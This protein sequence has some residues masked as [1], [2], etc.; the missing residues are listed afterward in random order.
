[1]I[2]LVPLS[3]IKK[4]SNHPLEPIH[5]P[6]MFWVSFLRTKLFRGGVCFDVEVPLEETL[7]PAEL[8]CV[9]NAEARLV[10]QVRLKYS[11]GFSRGESD[12]AFR[13]DSGWKSWPVWTRDDLP[14]RIAE[15]QSRYHPT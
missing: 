5:A 7:K 13:W 1:M 14:S 11:D 12:Y 10:I 2:L 15:E 9:S 3:T 8:M 6:D 4:Y